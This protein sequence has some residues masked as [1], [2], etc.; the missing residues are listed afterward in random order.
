M[1]AKALGSKKQVAYVLIFE[2]LLKEK[3]K[4]VGTK[5]SFIIIGSSSLFPTPLFFQRRERSRKKND[6]YP[7]DSQ[8][9]II[10]DLKFR[11]KIEQLKS[12]VV[13]FTR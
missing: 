9:D 13:S 11:P 8:G 1:S 2:T 12:L 6:K 4:K 5:P 10:S 7:V 3:K